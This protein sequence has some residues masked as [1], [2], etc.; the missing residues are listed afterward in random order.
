MTSTAKIGSIAGTLF[1]ILGW[2]ISIVATNGSPQ[3]TSSL[4]AM[5]LLPSAAFAQVRFL[6]VCA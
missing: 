4:T 5:C 2:G 1:Y 3:T 6:A